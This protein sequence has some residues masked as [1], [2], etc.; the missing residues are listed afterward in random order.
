MSLV[1]LGST[2]GSVT[3]QEP[4]VAGSTV[5]NLPS[6]IGNASTSAVVTTDASGNVG[7][8]VT[9]STWGS[10][11]KAYQVG[12]GSLWTGTGSPTFL[13]VSANSFY[14][15]VASAYVYSTTGVATDY[16]QNAGTHVWRTAASGTAG[17]TISFTQAMTLNANG[18][19]ALQ[20]ASTSA[21][22]VG[23]TFPATQSASSD[24]NTLDDYEEGAWTPSSFAG[25]SNLTGISWASGT[26]TRVG[27]LVTLI[28]EA[29]C[30]VTSSNTLTY[31][32]MAG[33]PFSTSSSTCG[34]A[35]FNNNIRTGSSQIVTGAGTVYA[36]FSAASAPVAGAE[37]IQ[38]CITYTAA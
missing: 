30:T 10:S 2:S 20:G 14:S 13:S 8:G 32:T 5:I 28:G 17:N 33:A 3:L 29:N 11:Y 19:L 12:Y 38:I 24:A 21:N 35:F 31:L 36:F 22:G 6:T 37:I 1:L 15:A 23:I 26:Y 9:P 27:R 34:N 18:V 4:A 16:Y 7:I 25:S